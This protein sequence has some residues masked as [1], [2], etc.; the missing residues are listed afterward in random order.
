M[1]KDDLDPVILKVRAIFKASGKT[2]DELGIAMGHEGDVARK[3]AWQFLNK[4]VDPRL[5]MLI[6]FAKAMS[7]P[8][9]DLTGQGHDS[10]V[11][12]SGEEVHLTKAPGGKWCINFYDWSWVEGQS[13]MNRR[14]FAQ[15][16]G[17]EGEEFETANDAYTFVERLIKKGKIPNKSTSGDSS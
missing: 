13:L 3:S 9:A 4:T 5:S 8:L 12:P 10:R 11:L 2:L 17:L 1:D 15:T 14:F 6:K 7:I 16:L